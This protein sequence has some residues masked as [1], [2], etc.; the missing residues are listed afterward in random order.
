MAEALARIIESYKKTEEI[1]GNYWKRLREKDIESD[2]VAGAKVAK[3]GED[4][5]AAAKSDGKVGAE[6]AES[7]EEDAKSGEEAAVK[8]D[9]D[10]GA[11]AA[12]SGG[13]G[14]TSG[15]EAGA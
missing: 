4:D 3:N 11:E 2:S 6:A 1:M 7:G 8:S 9:G 5:A 13:E 12:K 14:A 10:V 15:E